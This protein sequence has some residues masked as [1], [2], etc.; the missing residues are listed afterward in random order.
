MFIRGIL[1]FTPSNVDSFQKDCSR[2][3]KRLIKQAYSITTVSSTV[4]KGI[5]AVISIYRRN[6]I[7][8]C[9]QHCFFG[10]MVRKL[11][12][13]FISKGKVNVVVYFKRIQNSVNFICFVCVNPLIFVKRIHHYIS[14]IIYPLLYIH[15][16]ISIIIY[17]L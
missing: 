4:F 17:P 16:Y 11:T 3:F 2:N 1:S 6:M 12:Q 9:T 5:V 14:I 10:I 7:Q 13:L 8:H 15:Y